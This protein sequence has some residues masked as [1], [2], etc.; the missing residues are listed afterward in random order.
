MAYQ[1][2]KLSAS[3]D[4][5]NP[6]TCLSASDILPRS[7]STRATTPAK[8]EIR[9]SRL[10]SSFPSSIVYRPSSK[11]CDSRLSNSPSTCLPASDIL[12]R[13]DS[14][15]GITR[16]NV[17]SG[18]ISLPVQNLS[19]RAS[20]CERSLGSVSKLD[21]SFEFGFG[22]RGD[23]EAVGDFFV[24]NPFFEFFGGEPNEGFNAFVYIGASN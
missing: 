15:R 24:G 22:V 4:S 5:N 17:S 12:P 8:A 14:T 13:S 16:V 19:Q 11:L 3:R 10:E 21:Q 18:L 6:L 20:T 23:S 2:P 7:D 1:P 9:Y